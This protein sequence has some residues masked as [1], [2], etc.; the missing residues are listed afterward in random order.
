MRFPALLNQAGQLTD[1]LA[2][3]V[4]LLPLWFGRAQTAAKFT[5]SSITAA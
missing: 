4:G 5:P 1:A 2:A 3:S